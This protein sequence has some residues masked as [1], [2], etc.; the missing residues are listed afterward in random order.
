MAIYLSEP[1]TLQD[2]S[3]Q[4][5]HISGMDVMKSL[6]P[7]GNC[8]LEEDQQCGLGDLGELASLRGLV[9]QHP[10]SLNINSDVNSNS[11]STPE[12]VE[13]S[14]VQGMLPN[15]CVIRQRERAEPKCSS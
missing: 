8:T 11:Y 9:V 10:P 12:M 15:P 14:F 5:K 6:A 4:Q 3:L 2:H 7:Q 1:K 13:N